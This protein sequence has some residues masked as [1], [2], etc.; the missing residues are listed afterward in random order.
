MI[1]R[2]DLQQIIQEAIED[3]DASAFTGLVGSNRQ[4]LLKQ[5]HLQQQSIDVEPVPLVL[6]SH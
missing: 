2:E 1:E 4:Y 3:V 6:P 5:L